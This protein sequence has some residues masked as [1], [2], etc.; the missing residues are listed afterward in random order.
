MKAII[1]LQPENHRMQPILIR[2]INVET[3]ILGKLL[4]IIRSYD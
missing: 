4:K 1:R 2:E 3:V